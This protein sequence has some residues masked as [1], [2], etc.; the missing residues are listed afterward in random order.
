MSTIISGRDT[1]AGR[2]KAGA[3]W[4]RDAL[5]S[6]RPTAQ[7]WS[8]PGDQLSAP[9]GRRAILSAALVLWLVVYTLLNVGDLL[10]TY[11]GLQAGLHEANPLMGGLLAQN[12]FGALITYKLVVVVAVVGGAIALYRMHPR[13]AYLTVHVCNVLVFLAVILNVA[14]MLLH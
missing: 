7:P 5:P 1:R 4:K 8:A 6:A 10:S 11:F 14:Q 9:R 3:A 12:G 13:A 2:D